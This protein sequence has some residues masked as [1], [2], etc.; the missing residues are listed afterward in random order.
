MK[1]AMTTSSTFQTVPKINSIAAPE[2]FARIAG[3]FGESTKG[4]GNMDRAEK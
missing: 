2:K 1:V 4:L 3:I